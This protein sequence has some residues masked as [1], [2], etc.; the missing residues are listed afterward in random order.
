L[1]SLSPYTGTWDT[2]TAAHLQRRASYRS[3]KANIDHLA[4]LSMEDAVDFLFTSATNVFDYDPQDEDGY[5]IFTN[6]DDFLAT[7]WTLDSEKRPVFLNWLLG[8]MYHDNTAQEKL[9]FFLHTFFTNQIDATSSI[10]SYH[11]SALFRQFAFDVDSS[12]STG[13]DF[14]F[15]TLVKKMCT[16]EAM[17]LYLDTTKNIKGNLNENFCRELLEL[18]SI[19]KGESYSTEGMT[20]ETDGENIDY[21]FFKEE[22][23][24]TGARIFTGLTTLGTEAEAVIDPDDDTTSYITRSQHFLEA[25][26]DSM[27]GLP[28]AKLHGNTARHDNDPKTFSNRLGSTTITP[29]TTTATL[30][31]IEEEIDLFV[32]AIF[33]T[34]EEASK[35]ICRKLYRFYINREITSNGVDDIEESIIVP[36]AQ[37]FR[38]SGYKLQETVKTLL[39]SEHFYESQG[40]LIKTP[41]DYVLGS[42]NIFEYQFPAYDTEN[43]DYVSLTA[44]IRGWMK[45]KMDFE[46]YQPFEVAGYAPFHQA[47]LFDRNWISANTLANRY[48]YIQALLSGYADSLSYVENNFP[49]MG[50][51]PEATLKEIISYWFPYAEEDVSIQADRLDYFYTDVFRIEADALAANYWEDNWGVLGKEDDLRDI[52]E[53]AFN[54]ILQT[55]EFLLM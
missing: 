11:Q 25:Y 8:K 38:D 53:V 12:T 22:D 30:E 46:F 15:K 36:L 29:T 37:V 32:E 21:F 41:L 10:S 5:K 2:Q 17:V 54:S 20:N 14:N 1:A 26:Q 48:S 50:T 40:N 19:G 28:K 9:S 27:T 45:N 4:S 7:R 31:S 6:E 44:G 16:D 18:F 34:T 47:P 52:L 3:T 35:Y 39:K 43:E 42:L 23:I 51:T 33:N 55:P 13:E 49:D 24:E